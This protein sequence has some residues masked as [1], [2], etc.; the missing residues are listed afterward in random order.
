MSDERR[1]RLLK[2]E[3]E[4]RHVVQRT[5]LTF[6]GACAFGL[7]TST[8]PD[9]YLL[10]T[11]A[12]VELP[13]IGGTSF[14]IFIV[15]VPLVLIG[16]NV[17]LEIY[18]RHLQ[19][20]RTLST[21]FSSYRPPI[22]DENKNLLL[23]LARFAVRYMLLPLTL[24]AIFWTAS[25]IKALRLTLF[26]ILLF[27]SLTFLVLLV[28]PHATKAVVIRRVAGSWIIGTIIIALSWHAGLLDWPRRPLN[29]E[30]ANLE[31]ATLDRMDL[32]GANLRRAILS[33]ASLRCTNLTGADLSGANT[34]GAD[35]FSANLTAVTA[36]RGDFTGANMRDVRFT[37]GNF[38][39]AKFDHANLV[40][41]HDWFG[42]AIFKDVSMKYTQLQR[43]WG[44]MET[45]LELIERQN[46][47]L[48]CNA[49]VAERGKAIKTFGQCLFWWPENGHW[50]RYLPEFLGYDA[51]SHAAHTS[52]LPHGARGTGHVLTITSK[53]EQ[54]MVDLYFSPVE[55]EGVWIG[56]SDESTEDTWIWIEGPE[57]GRVFWVKKG[58]AANATGETHLYSNWDNE[59]PNN[60]GFQ[61][62]LAVSSWGWN[63]VKNSSTFPMVVEYDAVREDALAGFSYLTPDAARASVFKTCPLDREVATL[64]EPTRP[65][66]P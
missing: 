9:S 10:T 52:P 15:V 41:R 45:H 1:T 16:I 63:D 40:T 2:A 48:I 7:L 32:R 49:S 21:R 59:E 35:L 31:R 25:S 64:P 60:S 50:Y 56:A 11:G 27:Y 58:K 26:A 17:Y 43:Q 6:V 4:T 47:A 39:Q 44:D 13:L 53:A 12:T 28:G 66:P 14:R 54:A 34:Q 18:T 51:A 19:R 37:A 61:E 46:N 38:R 5:T 33:G 24:L 23:R 8:F 29:L 30:L 20:P 65:S 55:D 42:E 57:A 22:L 36:V 62:D 3:D